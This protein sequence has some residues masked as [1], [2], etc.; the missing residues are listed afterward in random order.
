[1]RCQV[2]PGSLI[3][4][5]NVSV[6]SAEQVMLAPTSFELKRGQALAVTGENGSGKTTLL[7]A[8]TGAIPI[9]DGS[10][11]IDGAT[12]D[13]RRSSF[14][15][16]VAALIGLPPFA[17]NLTLLEHLAL[18]SASWGI[19]VRDAKSKGA[20]TLA[21]FGIEELKARFPHELSS[22]QTQLFALALTWIRPFDILVLDEPEQRLDVDRV[23]MLGDILD[24]AISTG[25]TLI[26]ASHSRSL[27]DQVASQRL[28]VG[29]AS[30]VD[31]V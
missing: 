14:R 15:S 17:R 8:L 30:G 10:L 31:S 16:T 6:T 28:I 3:V 13:E 1:M 5:K 11:L 18:V 7:R 12:I 22:G 23:S 27:V 21:R 25:V 2:L 29:D 9:S 4:A 24:E 26:M 19:D 20:M